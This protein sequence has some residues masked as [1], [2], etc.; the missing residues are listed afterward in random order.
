MSILHSCNLSGKISFSN[1]MVVWL[2]FFALL[3][4]IKCQDTFAIAC[5]SLC[6]DFTLCLLVQALFVCHAGLQL[7]NNGLR[8]VTGSLM[9]LLLSKL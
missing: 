8:K 3:V 6:A 9:N 7:P 2:L 4:N 1:H 5:T